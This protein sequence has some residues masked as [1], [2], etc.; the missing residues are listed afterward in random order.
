MADPQF[1]IRYRQRTHVDATA[2]LVEDDAGKLHVFTE[3]H[4]HPYLRQPGDPDRRASTL[5][6]LGW[7]RVPEVAPYSLASLRRLLC[8]NTP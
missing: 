8:P 6:A 5:R 2:L 3:R 1:T 7:V 4:L